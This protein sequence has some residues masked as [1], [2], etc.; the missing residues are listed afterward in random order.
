MEIINNVAAIAAVDSALATTTD[1][2]LEGANAIT[3]PVADVVKKGWWTNSS[4]TTK[5]LIIG[6][7]LIGIGAAYYFLVHKK[8]DTEDIS[9]VDVTEKSEEEMAREMATKV[10]DSVERNHTIDP[11]TLPNGGKGCSEPRTA[12]NADSDFVKCEGKWY[13]KTKQN[14][15]NKEAIGQYSEWTPLQEGQVVVEQLN[16][17]Y[18]Q[19]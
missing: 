8:E 3:T 1:A 16:S 13:I 14:P 17:R 6:A 15:S 12:Y 9:H 19:D 7:A 4:T 2:L 5:A 18:P 11:S 10:I